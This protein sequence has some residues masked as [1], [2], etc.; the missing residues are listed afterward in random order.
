MECRGWSWCVC[1]C[2]CVCVCYW[3]VLSLSR[4][5]G[6][7]SLSTKAPS[8]PHSNILVNY[9]DYVKMTILFNRKKANLSAHS[10]GHGL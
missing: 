1:V 9:A 10:E 6:V 2:V 3:F 4:V 8:F 5:D 7:E